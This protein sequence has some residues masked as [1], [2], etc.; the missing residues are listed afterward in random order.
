MEESRRLLELMAENE[1]RYVESAGPVPQALVV[2]RTDAKLGLK[3]WEGG[4]AFDA[5][6]D[7]LP[8][9]TMRSSRLDV[10]Q[11]A[12]EIVEAYD[13]WRAG[14]KWPRG[15]KAT[16][17]AAHRSVRLVQELAAQIAETPAKAMAGVLAKAK[18]VECSGDWEEGDPIAVSVARDLLQLNSHALS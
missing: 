12:A 1:V 8:L 16:E 4:P 10:L 5:P 17:R 14:R 18:C 2:R 13:S 9:R 6:C 15:T 7:I 3:T 11:R